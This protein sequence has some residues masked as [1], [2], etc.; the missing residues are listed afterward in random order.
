VKIRIGIDAARI[1]AV[2][3]ART[4]EEAGASAI[5]VHGRT[6]KQGYSGN[7]DWSVIRKVKET[8]GIPVIGNG[9]V[10]SP[11]TFKKRLEESGVDYILI[12][13]G[14]IGKPFIFQQIN[15]YLANGE[16]RALTNVEQLD[17]FDEYLA[18]ATQYDVPF[19]QVRIHAQSFTTGQTGANRFRAGLVA[20]KSMEQLERA[21]RDYRTT[22]SKS[23]RA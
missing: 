1:N 4:I 6:Q 5:A 20:V 8:V 23:E 18:L 11:E 13:R 22:V 12:A 10:F 3:V 14:A 2:E 21:M 9:D 17:L 16:Y 15:E 7:A 19:Q